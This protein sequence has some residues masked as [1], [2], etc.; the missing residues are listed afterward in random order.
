MDDGLERGAGAAIG[1]H[2]CPQGRAIDRSVRAEDGR[3]ETLD[4]CSVSGCSGGN[5]L[6]REDIGVDRR[7]PELIEPPE[8]E[9]LA[10]RDSAGECGPQKCQAG[11][12]SC[13]A[14]SVFFSSIAIVSGPTPPGTGVSAPAT[15]TTDG[16]TS[17][18][19]SDPRLSNAASLGEPAPKICSIR[20]RS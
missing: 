1:E 8:A 18:T 2:D 3:T 20:V 11:V 16:C 12:R 13:A 4:H 5:R 10:G 6:S 17:P 9:T 14:R 15:S 19:T 7:D